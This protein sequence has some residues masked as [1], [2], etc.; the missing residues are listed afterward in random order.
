[1]VVLAV[2]GL[3]RALK[4]LRVRTLPGITC[5]FSCGF[6]RGGTCHVCHWFARERVAVTVNVRVLS[7]LAISG[8]FRTGPPEQFGD[9]QPEG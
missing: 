4:L 1:M 2:E 3:S 9:N 5:S 8:Q 6:S 7:L